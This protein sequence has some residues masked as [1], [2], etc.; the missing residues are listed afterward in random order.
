[1]GRL[2]IALN[3]HH[4]GWT[5]EPP[6]ADAIGRRIFEP[7]RP[8]ASQVLAFARDVAAAIEKSGDRAR[9]ELRQLLEV[10]ADD[11]ESLMLEVDWVRPV[12]IISD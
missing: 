1:M 5:I 7:F 8:D 6:L 11:D 10:I 9:T 12:G 2:R 3:E 4:S